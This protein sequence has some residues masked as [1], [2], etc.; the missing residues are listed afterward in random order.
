[1]LAQRDVVPHL[2]AGR[3]PFVVDIDAV[4]RAGHDADGT[5]GAE[6]GDDDHVKSVVEDSAEFRRAAAHAHIAADALRRLDSARRLLPAAWA[7]WLSE[8]IG[9]LLSLLDRDFLCH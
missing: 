5:P 3:S 4:D 9:P 2:I 7:R 6:L 8:P 1:A